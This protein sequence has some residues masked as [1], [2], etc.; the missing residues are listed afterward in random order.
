MTDVAHG[1][2]RLLTLLP[3]ALA[4]SRL[5]APSTTARAARAVAAPFAETPG[6]LV[7]G[8]D[9]GD[10]ARWAAA[11]SPP[12]GRALP[13]ASVRET[14]VGGVDGVTGA[15]QFDA[16]A[17]PDGATVLL[18]PGEAA[19]AWLVGNPRAQ[20]DISHW[21][22][23]LAGATP[24][25]LVG[26][27]ALAAGQR[28]RIGASGPSGPELSALL[29]LELLGVACEPVFGMSEAAAAAA[30]A[31]RETDVLLLRGPGVPARLAALSEARPLFTFGAVDDEGQTGRDLLAPEAPHFTELCLSMRG[32]GPGSPLHQACRAA[33]AAGQLAFGLVL[34]RL[35]P[36]AMVALWRHA[37]GAA[38]V[39]PETQAMAASSGTRPLGPQAAAASIGRI[40]ADG[41]SLLELRR[42]LAQRYDWHAG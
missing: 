8:P 34:P 7:A 28:V 26:R 30:F 42:W 19:H 36:P 14:T 15:N 12:L 3:L 13:A 24:G 41:S 35:T 31:R 18:A 5:A 10:L 25:I 32:P 39:A 37:G 17:A 38:A 20:F 11:L 22:P 29:A 6:L 40:A 2:R 9:G 27:A 23:V 1:R 33:A 4:A 21:V 16:R